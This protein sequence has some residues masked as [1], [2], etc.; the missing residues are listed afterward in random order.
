MNT[1]HKSNHANVKS[2]DLSPPASLKPVPTRDKLT[3]TLTHTPTTTLGEGR[4]GARPPVNQFRITTDDW[5]RRPRIM[6]DHEERLT[7]IDFQ[8]DYHT[9]AIWRCSMFEPFVILCSISTTCSCTP[10]VIWVWVEIPHCF[11]R[12]EHTVK[13]VLCKNTC[14]YADFG[15]RVNDCVHSFEHNF[16][17]YGNYVTTHCI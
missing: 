3:L 1:K 10:F 7:T 16:E 8:S 14:L 11:A 4:G 17:T 9:S 12:C 5:R 13:Q 6:T 15:T 2:R